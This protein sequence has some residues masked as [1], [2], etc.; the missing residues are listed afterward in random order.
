MVNPLALILSIVF[1]VVA[2]YIA[3]P[4]KRAT[5]ELIVANAQNAKVWMMA[6]AIILAMGYLAEK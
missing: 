5:T 4:Q 1:L 3:V 2:L 6:S